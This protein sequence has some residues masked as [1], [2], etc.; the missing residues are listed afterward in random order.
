MQVAVTGATG[1]IG[2]ALVRELAERGDQVTALSRNPSRAGLEV[3]TLE[4]RDPKRERPP[5]E[6]LR[7]RGG[8]VSAGGT[9]FFGPGGGGGGGGGGA[10]RP[11]LA[12]RRGTGLGGR[13]A[14]GA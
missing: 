4:W 12:R 13:G 8:P 11:R 10:G 1:T 3:E 9:G 6:A 2:R 5:A 14:Q 7:G